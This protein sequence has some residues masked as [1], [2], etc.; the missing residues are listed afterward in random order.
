MTFQ[1]PKA[2]VIIVDDDLKEVDGL[3]MA[4]KKEHVA[5]IHL[6]GAIETMPDSPPT[7]LRLLILDLYLDAARNIETA[8]QVFN[9]LVAD[10]C[11]PFVLVIWTT[12]DETVKDEFERFLADN[13][14]KK[15]LATLYKQKL[16]YRKGEVEFEFDRLRQDIEKELS[17]KCGAFVL[18]MDWERL[19]ARAAN[20]V[21][22]NLFALTTGS[23]DQSM[24]IAVLKELLKA[25]GGEFASGLSAQDRVRILYDALHRIHNDYLTTDIAAEEELTAMTSVLEQASRAL[26][27]ATKA[28]VQAYLLLDTRYSTLGVPLPGAVYD[29]CS[30][31]EKTRPW[32]SEEVIR[33]VLRKRNLREAKAKDLLAAAEKKNGDVRAILLEI[34]PLCDV[35]QQN[36]VGSRFVGGVLFKISEN[37]KL[38]DYGR[39]SEAQGEARCFWCD[40][41]NGAQYLLV[42]DFR[43]VTSGRDDDYR[44]LE[45]LLRL[46]EQVVVDL[47]ARLGR[48]VS[49]P[50]V[51]QLDF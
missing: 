2:R 24:A 1:L 23:T 12:Q 47:Q 32:R 33:E 27:A 28:R 46:R 18:L 31:P 7:D 15:P 9:S 51:V 20:Q 34:T 35:A 17:E 16:H 40:I 5:A 39:P 4:L 36:R 21:V 48:Q 30:L 37:A 19:V 8:K 42:I 26:D 43:F 10:G 45:P 38:K 13:P 6:D 14:Q 49:R 3:L 41:D 25:G 29:L 44:H 50:G 22:A 11:G